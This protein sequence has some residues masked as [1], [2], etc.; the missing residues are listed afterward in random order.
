MFKNFFT[1]LSLFL[2]IVVFSQKNYWAATSNLASKKL[3]ER[4]TQPTDYKLYSLNL[5]GIKNALSSAPQRFSNDESLVLK[6]PTSNGKM[7]D[8]V[9]QEAPV[10]APEL[11]AKFPDIRSYIGYQK[12][13][14]SNTVRFSVTP[15]DGLNAMYFDGWD[16]SYLDTYTDDKSTYM[17]YKRENLPANKQQFVCGFSEE[18]DIDS[19]GFTPDLALREPLVRDGQFRTYRLALACT[20]EYATYH[21]NRAGVSGGTTQ[22][23]KAAVMAAFVASMTRVNGVYEKTLSLTM[24]MVPNNDQLAFITSADYPPTPAGGYTNDNGSAMLNQNQTICNNIIGLAN[25]DIGHVFSTG[26]GGVAQLNSPCGS[27]RAR[28]VTGTSAPVN[29]AFNIDYVAHEMGHQFGGNHTFHATTSSCG[30][31]NR[32]ITTA[33]E[34]GS[35]ST[36]MAYAG[37]C[38]SNNNV[39]N[40]SNPYFHSI[41]VNEMYAFISRVNDCSAKVSNGNQVPVVD[42]GA[43]YTIPY[44]TPFAL[45]GVATDPDGDTLLYLWEQ[46]DREDSTQ[47]PVSTATGGPIFRSYLPTTSPTRYFPSMSYILANNMAYKWEMMPTVARNL[48][49]RL[50]VNDNRATGNQAARDDMKVTVANAG[51]FKVTSHTTNIEYNAANP[52][53][54]TW[55]V[56]GTASSPIDTQFVQILLSTNGGTSFDRILADVRNTGS[57]SVM[58]PNEDIASARLMVKATGNIYFALNSSAFKVKSALAVNDLNSKKTFAIYPNPAKGEVTISLAKKATNADYTIYDASGRLIRTAKIST[59]EKIN[60]SDLSSGV[61]RLVVSNNGEAHSQNL[62]IKK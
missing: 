58:L 20:V 4:N 10:M 24:V 21:V 50:L 11:Q 29:D 48:N 36:I 9:V 8:Y 53:T 16:V 46:M 31:G 55:D 28:G 62:V 51:P 61:Y 5:D 18:N 47:P 49:F 7:V 30:G 15:T 37:I 13:N 32:N 23:K 33:Y 1:L 42:A 19:G 27:G 38:G 59:S 45:T 40:N 34:P 14:T 26:G 2:S 3:K 44:G 35:G 41:S 52:T 57:A 22:Q 39:Q 12:D 43:D 56:A 6:L 54:V 25:Y 60:V 17:V